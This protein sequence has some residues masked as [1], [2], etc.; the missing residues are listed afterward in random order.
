[1]RAPGPLASADS[2]ECGPLLLI[3]E[4]RPCE[5]RLDGQVVGISPCLLADI[6]GGKATVELLGETRYA[7][8][9]LIVSPSIS[10]VTAWEPR[11]FGSVLCYVAE[12]NLVI[13]SQYTTT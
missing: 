13:I 10:A 5:V 1:M 7:R 4:G 11:L 2:L 8:A 3:K 12:I 9:E 6:P